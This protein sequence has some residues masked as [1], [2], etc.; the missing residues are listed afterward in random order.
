MRIKSTNKRE[1]NMELVNINGHTIAPEKLG[2]GVI[3]DVGC[4][5]FYF[6][7]N[8]IFKGRKIYAIDIDSEALQDAP[9]GVETLNLGIWDSEGEVTYYRNGEGTCV[10]E[11]W[12]PH[13]DK[14]ATAKTITIDQLYGITGTN[15]DLLKLDCEGAEYHILNEHFKPIPKQISVEFHYHCVPAVHNQ[16][17]DRILKMLEKDYEAVNLVWEQKHGAGFNFWDTLFVRKW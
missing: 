2:D 5:G 14:Y 16:H 4:R 10:K 12:E 6:C 17:I 13:K 7:T 9:I 15:V 1:K 8:E 3:I 11:V